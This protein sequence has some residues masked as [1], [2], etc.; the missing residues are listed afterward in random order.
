MNVEVKRAS[1]R[2]TLTAASPEPLPER[3]SVELL[4]Q[5]Q[6]LRDLPVGASR[7]LFE[8][9][10]LGG[11]TVLS[12]EVGGVA[13]GEPIA[14]FE[15]LESGYLA[16]TRNR[17]FLD[18]GDPRFDVSI[19]EEGSGFRRLSD[20]PLEL[21]PDAVLKLGD[22]V[23]RL[24]E[25]GASDPEPK[26]I[27][28]D[29]HVLFAHGGVEILARRNGENLQIL[30]EEDPKGFAIL[31]PDTHRWRPAQHKQTVV[32]REEGVVIRDPSFKEVCY[33]P[34]EAAKQPSKPEAMEAAATDS[35]ASGSL[36]TTEQPRVRSLRSWFGVR[37]D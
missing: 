24:P 5:S 16:V 22:F 6:E 12:L 3:S 37:H 13:R 21:G 19:L 14:T 29:S 4:M 28:R 31:D 7:D 10:C 26:S 27:D 8:R 36:V 32:F 25:G 18:A 15:K 17:K 30:I 20:R 33:R 9:E 34:A 35:W 11:S 23:R 2:G 1:W